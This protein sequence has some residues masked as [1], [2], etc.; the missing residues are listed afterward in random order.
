MSHDAK[1]P[2]QPQPPRERPR[3]IAWF[4]I[5]GIVL[6]GILTIVLLALVLGQDDDGTAT[7]SPTQSASASPGASVD[8][9]PSS[10]PQ[11]SA[12]SAV[13]SATAAPTEIALDT[14]VETIAEGV[15][16]RADPGLGGERLGSLAIGS[17]SYVVAGPSDADGFRWYLVSALGLPPNTGCAGPV[18]TDPYTCPAWFGWVAAASESGDPWLA[19]AETDCPA[20]PIV[21]E[22]LVIGR[23]NLQ[24]LTCFGAEPFTFRAWWPVLPD[25]AEPPASCAAEAEPSGWLL[26][27]ASND[28]YVTVDEGDGGLGDVGVQVSI[29]PASGVAMPERGTWVELTV[30]L[31]DPAAQGCDDAAQAL[32]EQP[33]PP[34]QYVLQCRAEMV[35]ESVTAVEGP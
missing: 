5:V 29:D 14:I 13:P 35:V 27:Q 3:P 4:S 32:E 25:D 8:G 11:P 1:P 20:E 6:L 17:P 16:L 9:S 28:T 24:R 34:E 2:L 22:D 31:D 7:T 19:P 33:Q 12:G 21:V 26:C 23:T 18:E 10:A 15:A 30:H